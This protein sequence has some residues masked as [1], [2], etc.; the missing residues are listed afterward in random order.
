MSVITWVGLG[1]MG[2]PMAL[3]IAGAG[4]EVRGVEINPVAAREAEMAGISIYSSAVEAIEGA[5]AVVTMLPTGAHVR[6]LLA[7][8]TGLFSV[9]S[10]TTLFVDSS[11]IDIDSA[12]EL[13]VLAEARELKFVDAPVSGGVVKAA[14]GTLTFMIGGSEES[15]A[16]A[17][18]IVAPMAA[19]IVYAGGPSTG[20]AAKIVNNLILGICLAGTCEGLL[21]GERLGLDADV[22]YDI[23]VSS[24]AENFA[25]R[26][27]YPA[28]GVVSSAPSSHEYAPGFTSALLHKDLSLALQAGQSTGTALDTAR[29]VHALFEQLVDSG[30]GG[31]DCTAL[32]PALDGR[33]GSAAASVP[34]ADAA[35]R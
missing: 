30:A 28:P 29:T 22:F 27:W 15:F 31:Y 17:S 26:E 2:L 3:Q 10:R 24:S 21:L 25:L 8:P 34:A 9:A 32:L 1:R 12:K 13:H 5:D 6:E 19:K 14:A 35:T 4:H 18:S 33:L 16:A 20:Q 7:G 23:A 11:T